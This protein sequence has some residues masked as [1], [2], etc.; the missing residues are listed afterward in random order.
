MTTETTKFPIRFAVIQS[1][2]AVF[3]VG[4]TREE[5]IADAVDWMEP[6]T[7]TADVESMLADRPND[8]DFYIMESDDDEFD[9]YMKNQHAF[10][11]VNG[12]WFID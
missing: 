12:E 9:C 1:G 5:A 3:G 2:Y 11:N 6:G 8:G 7:T 10:K 4:H